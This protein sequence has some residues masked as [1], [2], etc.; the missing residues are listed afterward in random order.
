M[1]YFQNIKGVFYTL[2]ALVGGLIL[3]VFVLSL[4]QCK[5][6]EKLPTQTEIDSLQKVVKLLENLAQKSEERAKHF[7]RLAD[8]AIT[9]SLSIQQKIKQNEKNIQKDTF[10]IR[11][12]SDKQLQDFFSEYFRNAQN[13]ND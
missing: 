10:L 5:G 7:E 1:A 3:L 12:Y 8:S 6:K 13:R 4:R 2:L 11:S 9:K